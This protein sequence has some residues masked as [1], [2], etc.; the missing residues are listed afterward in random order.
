MIYYVEYYSPN[1]NSG[2]RKFASSNERD[3][4]LHMLSDDTQFYIYQKEK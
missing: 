4:F 3:L 1:G 2:V